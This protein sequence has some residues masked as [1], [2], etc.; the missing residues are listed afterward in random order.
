MRKHL[1][2]LA[3]AVFLLAPAAAHA[4]VT[5]DVHIGTPPPPPVAYRV[6]PQPGPGYVWVEGYQY[7]QG[8]HYKW[9]DGYWTRPPYTGAYWVAP[10]HSNSQYYAGHWEGNHGNVNHNHKSDH[11]PQRDEH[12]NGH[13]SGTN[14]R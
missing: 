2:T 11:S 12:H 13:P 7:P 9:H 1:P 14:N 8:G 6:P 3:L 5:F 10:Y 4:Q